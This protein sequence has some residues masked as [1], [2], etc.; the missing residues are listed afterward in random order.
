MSFKRSEPIRWPSSLKE[1][2]N[3]SVLTITRNTLRC[4]SSLHHKED[5]WTK[6]HVK[7]L[8]KGKNYF[9]FV[10]TEGQRVEII[11]INY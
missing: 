11:V 5:K 7:S 3:P 1:T 2:N 9:G 10:A 6:M 4:V 8:T